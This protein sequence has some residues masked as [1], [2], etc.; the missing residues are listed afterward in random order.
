MALE[1]FRANF[2]ELRGMAE[3]TA[4]TRAEEITAAFL[5]QLQARGEAALAS[6]SDPDM[7]RSIF[8]AQ[9][10]Y[11]CSGDTDLEAVLVD[12]LVDR[13]DPSTAQGMQKIV[14]NEAIVAAPKLTLDQRRAIAV[15][16]L[17]RY[18]RWAGPSLDRLY[19]EFIQGNV[20]PLVADA[21]RRAHSYQHIEYVGAGSIGIGTVGFGQ[22]ISSKGPGW[23]TTGFTRQEVGDILGNLLDNP[24]LFIEC[25]RDSD[26]LQL[27]LI[28]EEDLEDWARSHGVADRVS[29]LRSVFHMGRVPEH[30]IREELC[31]RIPGGADL[32]ALWT[33]T[34]LQRMQL[35]SVGIAIGHGYWRRV[36]GGSAPL[37]IWIPA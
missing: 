7:Q 14:L 33:D 18:T 17:L 25:L 3:E 9:R 4:R 15:C 19:E 16:F 26:R 2:L 6:A 12:L 32:I 31:E 35:T 37:S 10:E 22:A 20:M 28:H 36:T 34:P 24:N 27:S 29:A 8:N 1:V 30:V 13:A 11:A 23:F 21:S 5:E